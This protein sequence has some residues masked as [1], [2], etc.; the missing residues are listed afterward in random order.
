[1]NNENNDNKPQNLLFPRIMC[2]S[3]AII[4][5]EEHE[6][7]Q[8]MY[9]EAWQYLIDTGYAWTLQGWY[10]R[11]AMRMIEEGTCSM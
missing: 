6:G 7:D 2:L 1:M 10:G 9:I 11:T 8:A 5:I 3:D 4:C